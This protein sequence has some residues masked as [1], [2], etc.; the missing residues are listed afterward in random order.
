[1]PRMTRPWTFVVLVLALLVGSGAD[2]SARAQPQQRREECLTRGPRALLNAATRL[3]HAACA[4]NHSSAHHDGLSP[5][6]ATSESGPDRS[7]AIVTTSLCTH[8]CIASARRT[9]GARAPP[10]S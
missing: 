9:C 4:R 6:R 3:E 10:R 1:M 2:V 7:F 8:Q 5:S